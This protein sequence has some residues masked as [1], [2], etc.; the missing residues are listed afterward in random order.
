MLTQPE[1]YL[2][3]A[4][5]QAE[6]QVEAEQAKENWDITEARVSKQVRER[7]EADSVKA[8]A[9]AVEDAVKL[10]PDYQAAFKRYIEARGEALVLT[11]VEAAF[12]MR[13]DALVNTSARERTLGKQTGIPS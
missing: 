10:H 1:L 2:K 11:K 3:W 4:F 12:K 13:M 6:A 5:S 8:T 9:K 7:F